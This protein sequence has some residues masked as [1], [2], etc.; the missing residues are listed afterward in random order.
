M[1]FNI[2]PEMV[3]TFI[4]LLNDIKTEL[5]DLREQSTRRCNVHNTVS[6]STAGTNVIR[7]DAHEALGLPRDNVIT[8]MTVIDN[9][10]GFTFRLNGEDVEITAIDNMSIENEQISRVTITCGGAAGT[11]KV[12]FGGYIKNV[13]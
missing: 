5:K 4:R 12:R 6:F 13:S 11:A 8:H 7:Y 10:G 2:N 9:G 3:N 1:N